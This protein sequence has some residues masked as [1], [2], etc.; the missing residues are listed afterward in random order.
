M[1]GMFKTLRSFRKTPG[2]QLYSLDYTADYQLDRLLEMG[3]G[4][5][6]EFAGNVCKLLL[7]LSLIHI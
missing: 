7:N 1:K 4:S 6:S 2:S 3:A 5:D